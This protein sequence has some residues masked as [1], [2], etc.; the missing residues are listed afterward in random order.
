MGVSQYKIPRMFFEG[1]SVDPIV[2]TNETA[3]PR[4][5]PLCPVF[6]VC[7]GCSHQDISYEH[8][9]ALKEENLKKLF[10][11]KLGLGPE[12]FDSIVASPQP[13]HYRNRLDLTLRRRRDGIMLGFQVA[14]ARKMIEVEACPIA[15][16]EISEFIPQLKLDAVAKLPS[17]YRNAN[18]V[19][20]TGEDGRVLWGGIGRRSLSLQEK[21]YFWTTV[22]GRKIFY[23]LDTFFQANLFILPALMDVIEKYAA[24]DSQT[25][26]LDLYSGTGLFGLAF[27]DKASKVFMIEENGPS[28]EAAAYALRFHSLTHAVIRTGKVETELPAVLGE[29]KDE[30]RVIAIVDPPRH[31]LSVSALEAIAAE[32]RLEKLFYLSCLP[33]SLARDLVLFKEKGWKIEKVIPFDFFPRTHHLET[34]VLLTPGTRS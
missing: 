12:L 14:A 18:L 17:D 34:L 33:E 24:F 7:G 2:M 25:C 11:E 19:V 22:R 21:D 13:Y 16:R 3:L 15:R 20:R 27:A 32:K 29:L 5:E 8:E 9:L 28:T 31:G 23:S 6:G 1:N 26:F 4:V 10:A 30:K